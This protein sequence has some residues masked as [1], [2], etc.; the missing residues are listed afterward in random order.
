MGLAAR[1]GI[2]PNGGGEA[3]QAFTHIDAIAFDKTGTIT[4]GKFQVS[5]NELLGVLP[6]NDLWGL[7]SV[8]EQ[9]SNHP[10]AR[11]IDLS[12]QEKIKNLNSKGQSERPKV[13]DT[14]EVPG[15]GMK[16]KVKLQDK[17][18]YEALVG[19]EKLLIENGCDVSLNNFQLLQA[20]QGQGKS[21]VLVA[22]KKAGE[23]KTVQKY[24][25][26]ALLAVADP[27]RAEARFV[28]DYFKS[29]GIA[30]YIVSGDGP[31]TVKAVAR[32]LDLPEER[33]VGGAMPE[34]KRRFVEQ[35][36]SQTKDVRGWNGKLQS[37]HKLVAFVGDGIND[38]IGRSS[39]VTSPAAAVLTLFPSTRA[40]RCVHS[41]RWRQSC[42]DGDSRLCAHQRVSPFHH[43]ASSHSKSDL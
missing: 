40:S 2:M 15:R 7:I 20:W 5:D 4:M 32:V 6:E 21:V 3:F 22:V 24:E 16:A 30:T 14:E 1:N 17:S 9:A 12:A 34:D 36:Q 38:S 25:I 13:L 39:R 29:R 23:S 27:L 41:T 35:L 42:S 26:A 31:A 8:V 43:N 37:K 28:L 11:A 33:V 10:V 18:T 19:N